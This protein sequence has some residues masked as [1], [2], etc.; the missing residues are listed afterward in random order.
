MLACLRFDFIVHYLLCDNSQIIAFWL[1]QLI[2]HQSAK[3]ALLVP[4]CKEGCW[5]HQ[6]MTN[7]C[8]IMTLILGFVLT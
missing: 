3:I 8:N 7:S 4:V 5:Y 6:I 1:G 2:T